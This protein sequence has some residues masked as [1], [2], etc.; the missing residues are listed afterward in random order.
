MEE[1]GIDY[2]QAV[3]TSE[4]RRLDGIMDSALS[5]IQILPSIIYF[6]KVNNLPTQLT[7]KDKSNQERAMF[8]RMLCQLLLAQTSG[9]V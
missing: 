1:T 5:S 8:N 3:V 2:L 9:C 6:V 4:L 7:P